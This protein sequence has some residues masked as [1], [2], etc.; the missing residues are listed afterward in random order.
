MVASNLLSQ[1]LTGSSYSGAN[2]I[3]VTAYTT[4]VSRVPSNGIET[5]TV[6]DNVPIHSAPQQ[7][8]RLRVTKP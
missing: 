6:R 3:P 7:F 2:V 5:I 1:W 8:M 4:E